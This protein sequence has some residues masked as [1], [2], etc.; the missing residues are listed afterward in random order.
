MAENG[1][2]ETD[3]TINVE[4]GGK[5][6]GGKV[7]KF[8][9][10]AAI[11][12]LVA[13]VVRFV[14]G[15]RAG[16][17]ENEWQELPPPAG[18][19]SPGVPGD[20]GHRDTQGRCVNAVGVPNSPVREK[21]GGPTCIDG[22]RPSRWLAASPDR[23]PRAGSAMPGRTGRIHPDH[24]PLRA[25]AGRAGDRGSGSSARTSESKAK[26]GTGA[27][28]APRSLPLR[29]R[30]C[31]TDG[32]GR[33]RCLGRGRLDRAPGRAPRHRS[34]QRRHRPCL[35]RSGP[36]SRAAAGA[37][38]RRVRV[39]GRARPDGWGWRRGRPPVGGV[40]PRVRGHRPRTHVH[41]HMLAVMPEWQGRGVGVALKLGQRAWTQ[42]VGIPEVRWN[43]TTRCCCRREVQPAQA[44][45]CRR[46]VRA[47]LLRRHGR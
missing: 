13:G 16:D 8:F 40:R 19:R 44:G 7:K 1:D 27:R 26:Q 30:A 32:S 6:K 15:R 21:G 3:V 22:R 17:E 24:R 31:E 11:A 29:Y 23:G 9:L 41:S 35:G 45:R 39:P 12:A 20:P 34:S 4:S 37:A 43:C 33:C 14:K 38:A 2:N 46:E 42:D 36:R 5:K 25:R 28:I 18:S 10:F 47:E